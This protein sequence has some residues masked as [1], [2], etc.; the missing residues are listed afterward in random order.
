MGILI[1]AYNRFSGVGAASYSVVSANP[2]P[3][4]FYRT[5][6]GDTPWSIANNVYV[7]PGLTSI[8]AG[9][10]LLNDNIGNYHIRKAK[11]GW[12][13]YGIK[14]LQFTPDYARES[15]PSTHGTGTDFP[16]LWIPQITGAPPIQKAQVTPGV[17]GDKGDKG[18]R[19]LPGESGAPGQPGPAASQKQIASLVNDFLKK[20]PPARGQRGSDGQP[21]AD[22]Q[23][24]P[25]AS[26]KQISSLV[27]DFLKKNPPAK[28][29]RGSRGLPGADGQT[30]ADGQPGTGASQLQISSLVNDFLKKNPPARGQRGQAGAD[31][32]PGADGQPGPA[33]SQK[34]IASLV[35]DFLQ[36]NPPARGQRGE[37]GSDGK[38]GTPGVPGS[39]G[40]DAKTSS[41]NPASF[42]DLSGIKLQVLLL[43]LLGATAGA[44]IG[45]RGSKNG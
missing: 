30:G 20:N 3:G 29:Q 42:L 41:F 6:K 39:D 14:G 45:K 25:A 35:N 18:Q 1:P 43:S 19:G 31:G 32:R 26:Q 16:L 7:K 37:P 17:K 12:T 4:T 38:P 44:W 40:E 8:K 9:L 2:T 24:G 21:G 23:P 34:Q 22:G 27:N 28:G 10:M 36:K 15:Y 33:A 13:S 11:S 5:K